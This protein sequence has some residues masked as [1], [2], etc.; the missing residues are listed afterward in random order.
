MRQALLFASQKCLIFYSTHSYMVQCTPAQNSKPY[1]IPEVSSE[2]Y[3][4]TLSLGKLAFIVLNVAQTFAM[5]CSGI[6]QVRGCLSSLGS[7]ILPDERKAT[8]RGGECYTLA[9]CDVLGPLSMANILQAN[10]LH[11]RQW[12]V[13]N[14]PVV[15]P[16]RQFEVH[17]K[18][19]V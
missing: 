11:S 12:S 8:G 4:D 18:W 2:A 13:V 6:P 1:S 16:G 17:R 9:L 10:I 15:H 14:C 5:C 7:T 19:P 3:L